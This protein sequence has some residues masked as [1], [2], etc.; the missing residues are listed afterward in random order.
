MCTQN[1]DTYLKKYY[2]KEAFSISTPDDML[3]NFH[4]LD[5][6]SKHTR[7]Y[8]RIVI[9]NTIL[10][11]IIALC[12]PTT[13]YATVSIYQAVSSKVNDAGLSNS[14]IDN[15][16]EK[17]EKMGYTAEQILELQSLKKN[18]NGQTYGP[19]VL[20]A[21]L[22]LVISIE[23]NVGYVYREDLDSPGPLDDNY[24]ETDSDVINVYTNDGK[25]II[26]TFLLER[27]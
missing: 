7:V 26:G 20:E 14:E 10:I 13:V 15:L 21:D 1:F 3:K 5:C 19:E 2:S 22:V 18:E 23:G 9:F 27:N 12:I 17:L 11:L 6:M 24:V 4:R 25:T 16:S 8:K